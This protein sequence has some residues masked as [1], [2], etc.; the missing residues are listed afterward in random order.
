MNN[1]EEEQQA[2][3]C[4]EIYDLVGPQNGLFRIDRQIQAYV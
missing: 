4:I 2:R 1:S 3:R